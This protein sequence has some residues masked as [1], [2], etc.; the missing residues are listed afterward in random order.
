MHRHNEPSPPTRRDGR[1]KM[2]AQG[3]KL[4]RLPRHIG[5][6]G[7]TQKAARARLV[8]AAAMILI[9]AALAPLSSQAK[10]LKP[11]TLDAFDQYVHMREAGMN[12][13]LASGKKFLWVDSLPESGRNEAYANLKQG[14]IIA[15]RVQSGGEDGSISIPG[16]LIH[17]WVGIVYIPGV[18]L[19]QAMSMLQDYDHD[20]EYYNPQVLKSKLVEHSGND[21]KIFLRL[22]RVQVV[23][24]VLDTDYDVHFTTLDADHAISSSYSTRI[25]EVENAG[26]PQESSKPVGNDHGF[27]WRLDTYWRFQQADGGVYVQCNAIS[28]TRDIPVGLAWLIKPFIQNIPGDSV[29]FTLGATRKA[30]ENKS[31]S[32]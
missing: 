17:D 10:Q 13:E 3:L 23:T 14:Q 26:E 2:S 30:L 9:L 1:K 19:P 4:V 7:K 8:C 20:T 18:T 28:L 29:R 5:L 6:V 21:F 16:G 24:V 27:L 32:R 31:A 25:V 12:Q 15:Q 22:K 11:K